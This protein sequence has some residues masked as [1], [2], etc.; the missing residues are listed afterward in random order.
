[1]MFGMKCVINTNLLNTVAVSL[2]A[3]KESAA[4]SLC[5]LAIAELV[6]SKARNLR[7][8]FVFASQPFHSSQ[9]HFWYGK[10]VEVC[11]KI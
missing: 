5:V 8:S 9:R 3:T 7:V 1:M 4:I 2:R 11:Q 10:G 6:L